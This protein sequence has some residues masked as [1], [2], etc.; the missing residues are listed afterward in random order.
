MRRLF[1][2]IAALVGLTSLQDASAGAALEVHEF[3]LEN[4]LQVVVVPI[5]RSHVVSHNLLIHAGASDD[6]LGHSG[7]AHFLEHMQFK[8]TPT[9]PEGE[10]SRQVERLGGQYNAFTTADMTGY[11]VTI[12]KEHLPDIMN[13]E[14]DRMMHL[15]PAADSYITERDVVLEER[16]MRTDNIPASLLSEA[17]EAALFRHHPYGTPIIGWAH[18]MVKLD[19][20]AAKAFLKQYYT[21]HNVVLLLVG[22]IDEAEAKTLATTYYGPWK[23]E[24]APARNWVSEP[25]RITSEVVTLRHPTVNVREWERTYIAPSFGAD[26]KETAARIMPLVLAEEILGH[27]R[28]GVLYR[29][30]VE[31]R[32][33]ATAVSI[34]Y[35]PYMIGPGTLEVGITP[36]EGVSLY[37]LA[38]AYVQTMQAFE[39]STIDAK[40]MERAR[41]QLKAST[42]F[43]RDSIQGM[44]SILSQLVM[45]GLPPEWFNRWPELV[46][47]VTPEQVTQAVR[48][49]CTDRTAVTGVLLPS[50]TPLPYEGAKPLSSHPR[51]S[52][53]IQ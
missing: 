2:L 53:N 35:N 44:A 12:A 11:Y 1:L 43:A 48:Q 25:P 33:V 13:L 5:H 34:G 20:V 23:G 42:I 8:G 28:T 45:I 19:E 18:E 10:Y 29:E 17:V 14:A 27:P 36:A 22:D 16:R 39:K 15:A 31:K 47:A 52:G 3:S 26:G 24:K 50:K 7:V 37:Q 38:K 4:G 6:P 40:V 32:K 51:L 41:N 49:T 9:H 30:L 21:P 46:D